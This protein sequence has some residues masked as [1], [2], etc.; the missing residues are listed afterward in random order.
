MYCHRCRSVVYCSRRCQKDDWK[1]HKISCKMPFTVGWISP[2]YRCVLSRDLRG[3]KTTL[4]H[5][6]ERRLS[7]QHIDY[8]D[9]KGGHSSTLYLAVEH[10]LLP[11]IHML[12]EGGANA[13]L[14][15]RG[16]APLVEN[17]FPLPG[18]D[19]RLAASIAKLLIE[20]GADPNLNDFMQHSPLQNAVGE[21]RH[22]LVRTL[23]EG[24]ANVNNQDDSGCTAL[25]A[26][27]MDGCIKSMRVLHEFKAD[28]TLCLGDSRS[29]LFVACENGHLVCVKYLVEKMGADVNHPTLVGKKAITPLKIAM[30]SK[31]T[32]I[33]RYL[34]NRGGR[35]K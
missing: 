18:R 4:E 23:L 10:Q 26:S 15:F 28:Q 24:K 21:D 33:A 8:Q 6:Q 13:N 9:S 30:F 29:P 27:A 3:L 14:A 20:R 11:M 22:H 31:R 7:L 32:D 34:K 19:E 17:S 5:I 16:F 25:W 1:G 2:I 12:L 35:L